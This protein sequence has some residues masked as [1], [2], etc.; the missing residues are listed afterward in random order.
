[1]RR[2]IPMFFFVLFLASSAM[3][4]EK[5]SAI[6][7]VHSNAGDLSVQLS[8][9][10][11]AYIDPPPAPT[12]VANGVP[13]PET[14]QRE[15]FTYD[16]ELE[17]IMS[18]AVRDIEPIGFGFFPLRTTVRIELPLFDGEADVYVGVQAPEVDQGEMWIVKQDGSFHRLSESGIVPWKTG[19]R[20]VRTTIIWDGETSSLAPA[21]YNVYV[22]VTRHGRT[23]GYYIWHTYFIKY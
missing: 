5:K 19:V 11:V 14:G 17:P 2:I 1:M 3:A 7:E 10:A 16:P 21:V 15:F 23:D 12:P 22:G 13:M 8:G 20:S 18:E 6:A 4:G 9:T